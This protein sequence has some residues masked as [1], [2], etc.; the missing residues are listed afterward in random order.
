MEAQ[1]FNNF[2]ALLDKGRK[3]LLTRAMDVNQQVLHF[4]NLEHRNLIT[5]LG[6]L[7]CIPE[8]LEAR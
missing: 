1:R 7:G 6:F 8:S 2:A 5:N 3:V 4:E